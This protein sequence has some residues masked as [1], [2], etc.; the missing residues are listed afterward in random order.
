M[1]IIVSSRFQTF[2]NFFE[3]NVLI[4]LITY[5]VLRYLCVF[6]T[7]IMTFQN[8]G[9]IGGFLN[10]NNSNIL[11]EGQCKLKTNRKNN[12]DLKKH[13]KPNLPISWYKTLIILFIFS[14]L[15]YRYWRF[16]FDNISFFSVML[17][18]VQIFAGVIID[19]FG[20]LRE[21]EH[22]KNNDIF[23]TCFICG[24]SRELF[25]RQSDI[26]FDSHIKQDHY[27]WNYL[28]YI[29]FINWKEKTDHSGIESFVY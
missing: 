29:A 24:H 28:F 22:E 8:N 17:I 15:A 12:F 7:F 27:L 20:S 14:I 13:F 19:K 23:Q 4:T 3:K 16:I 6:H 1:R 18:S 9:G 21:R 11:D 2:Y 26:G 5:F 10:N 25:E